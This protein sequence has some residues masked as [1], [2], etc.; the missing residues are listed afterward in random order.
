MSAHNQKRDRAFSA[1]VLLFKLRAC[2]TLNLEF[3]F[4]FIFKYF[5][6]NDDDDHDDDD[7]Q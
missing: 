5:Q 3:W 6:G 2:A 4:D 7:E 1:C